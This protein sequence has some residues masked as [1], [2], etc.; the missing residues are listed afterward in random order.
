MLHKIH[1]PDVDQTENILITR[2]SWKLRIVN[3]AIDYDD[4]KQ[5]INT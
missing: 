2:Q 5:S 3:T 4:K 1:A